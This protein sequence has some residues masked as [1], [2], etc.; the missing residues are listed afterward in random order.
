MSA[1]AEIVD[2]FSYAAS[3]EARDVALDRV[4]AGS[5]DGWME[6]AAKAVRQVAGEKRYF[7][8]DDIWKVLEKPR[9]PRALGALMR[10][11]AV[12]GFIKKTGQYV[13][14][15]QVLRHSAPIAVWELA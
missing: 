14:T 15:A 4:E 11:M 1:K 12:A 8:T 3:R 2:L 13:P 7:T 9:E 6:L 10:R 5:P